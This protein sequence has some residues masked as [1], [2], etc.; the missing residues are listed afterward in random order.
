MTEYS[1][2][3]KQL[4]ELIGQIRPTDKNYITKAKEHTAQLILPPRALGQLHDIAEK[5][6]AIQENLTPDLTRKAIYVM[7]G[8]HGIAKAGVS[9]FP[10]EVTGAM[11]L[12]FLNGQ[13]GVSVLS[14]HARAEV[15]VADVGIIPDVDAAGTLN[16]AR[17]TVRKVARGTADISTGPAMTRTQA[18][19]AVL[20]GFELAGAIFKQG[21]QVLGTGDMGIGNTTPSAALGAV[22]TGQPVKLMTGPGTGLSPEGVAQKAAL[23][24][25]ALEVNRPEQNDPLAV[26]AKVGGFEIGAIAGSILAG[27]HY[28][29]AVVA[30]GFIS[31]AGALLAQALCP[32]I[33]DYIFAAHQSE[34]GGHKYMWR[35]L[36]LN[37]MLDLGMRLGE[38]SGGAL[39]MTV[40][41]SAVKIF[42]EMA[43]FEEANVPTA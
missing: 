16:A 21:V 27:G 43:T 31:T 40:M 9:A 8:D 19:Q 26:L 4:R 12:S 39:A 7:A 11:V 41:E 3:E 6:V 36:G 29:R 24:A 14:R 15:Y 18:A 10:Q 33:T 35:H 23:I 22:F 28:R 38:G 17:F 13:A 5:I 42:N 32:C 2:Q 1:A 30:D 37:P 34:E 20:T 25:K